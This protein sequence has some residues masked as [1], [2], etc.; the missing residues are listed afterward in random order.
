MG[1]MHCRFQ[2]AVKP[3]GA[4]GPGPNYRLA[5]WGASG[6]RGNIFLRVLLTSRCVTMPKVRIVFAYVPAFNG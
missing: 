2:V 3:N 1:M 6:K 5:L 4:K